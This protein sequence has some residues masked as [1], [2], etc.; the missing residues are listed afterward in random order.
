MIHY[1]FRKDNTNYRVILKRNRQCD[2][3]RSEIVR[4]ALESYDPPV[5]KDYSVK[6]INNMIKVMSKEYKDSS[7]LWE[8]IDGVIAEYNEADKA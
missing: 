8:K 3:S 1:G 6:F 5:F 4:L 2:P 7:G